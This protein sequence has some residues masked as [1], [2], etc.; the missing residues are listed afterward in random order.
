MLS[1]SCAA[2][3][4]LSARHQ[5]EN[6]SQYL[7]VTQCKAQVL[8]CLTAIIWRFTAHS[9]RWNADWIGCSYG[10]YHRY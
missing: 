8:A 9:L 3:S 6:Q 2:A 7:A 5:Q 10:R 1:C 4:R